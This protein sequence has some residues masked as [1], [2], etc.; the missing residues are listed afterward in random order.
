MSIHC[1]DIGTIFRCTIYD[2]NGDIVDIS[3]ASGIYIIFKLPNFTSTIKTASFYTDGTDGVLQ[4]I[5]ESGDISLSGQWSM[6]AKIVMPSGTW[7]SDITKFTV[8]ENL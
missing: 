8:C 3:T 4:Y 5:A 7:F 1:N 2:E 6:Q